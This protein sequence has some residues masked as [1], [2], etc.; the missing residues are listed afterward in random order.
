MREKVLDLFGKL[1]AEHSNFN[2]S[3]EQLE[4]WTRALAGVPAKALEDAAFR[5]LTTVPG[6]PALAKFLACLP[7]EFTSPAGREERESKNSEDRGH[8]AMAATILAD[9]R[10]DGES[11]WN[12]YWGFDRNIARYADWRHRG[13]TNLTQ[14]ASWSLPGHVTP[15]RPQRTSEELLTFLD[16]RAGIGRVEVVD[17]NP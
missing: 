17:F 9:C 7:P 4:L 13:G 5:Y 15:S 6:R 10:F 16:R 8:E 3:E 14:P 11:F 12:P 1:Q 2:P